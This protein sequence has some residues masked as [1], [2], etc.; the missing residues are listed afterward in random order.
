MILDVFFFLLGAACAT[1]ITWWL[2]KGSP[3]EKA[4]L[5]AKIQRLEDDLSSRFKS[6]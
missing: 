5:K 4:A 1:G 2:W 6:S 3:T